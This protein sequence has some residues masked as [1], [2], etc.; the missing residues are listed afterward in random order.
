MPKDKVNKICLFCVELP[1][2]RSCYKKH[3]NWITSFKESD[4]ELEKFI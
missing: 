1:P 4:L 3:K 2:L